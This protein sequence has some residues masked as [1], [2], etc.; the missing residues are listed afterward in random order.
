MSY[1]FDASAIFKAIKEE[2]IEAL[3][4]NYTIELA[5]YELGNVLWKE[6]TLYGKIQNKE[7][8]KVIKTI[9]DL[10]NL[11]NVLN[12]TCYEEEI[13]ALAGK[14][15]LTFYDASYVH[16]A[17]KRKLTLVTEDINLINKAK[18]YTKTIRFES[19]ST[20]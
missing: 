17:S 20:S 19:I 2:K 13:L 6:Q 11:L 16:L 9:K 5:R 18:N 12:I 15:N 10:F 1:L 4:G 7:A 14:T 3:T 8:E